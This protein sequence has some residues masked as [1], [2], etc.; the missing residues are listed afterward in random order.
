MIGATLLVIAEPAPTPGYAVN[1]PFSSTPFIT[2]NMQGENAGDGSGGKWQTTVRRYMQQVQIMMLQEVGASPPSTP[3]EDFP[4]PD[5]QVIGGHSVTHTYWAPESST[6]QPNPYHVY[7]VQTDDNG[8]RGTGGRVNT[9]IVT[10]DEPDDVAV[11]VNPRARGR[12]ALGVRFGAHWY[13]S[14][15]GL[16]RCGTDSPHMVR[17]IANQVTAW[18]RAAGVVYNW[19]VAGDFNRTPGNLAHASGDPEVEGYFYHTRRATHQ[20]G[21]ELDY[22][23]SSDEIID[24]R[25]YRLHGAG[26][27]HFPVQIGGLQARGEV[28]QPLLGG[29]IVVDPAGD[30]IAVGEN[31]SHKSGYRLPL[32]NDLTPS[33]LENGELGSINIDG[34]IWK[35]DF[36][37]DQRSGSVADP[38]HDGVSGELID[39]IRNR[40]DCTVPSYR[41]NVVTLHAGTNDM[42]QQ[43]ELATAPDRLGKLIDQI[44]EDA[45]EAVILVATLIPSTKDGMQPRI[46]AY[47]ARVPGVVKDRQD[48]GKHVLLADMSMVTTADVDGSHP[49]DNG[50]RKMADVF[51]NEIWRAATRGWIKEPVP[52]N[53]QE[54][55]VGSKAGPGWRALGTIAPGMESPEGKTDLVELNGDNRADYVRLSDSRETARAALNMPGEPG[56]PN[57]VEVNYAT[58]ADIPPLQ[59]TDRFAD[60]DGDGRDDRVFL[61]DESGELTSGP[62]HHV[63]W[64]RNEGVV[65]GVIRWA[66]QRYYGLDY[67]G[68]PSDSIRFADIDGDGHDDLLRVGESGAIHAYRWSGP[69]GEREEYL[70]WAPGVSGGSRH[71]LRLAD[72]NGDRKADYLMVQSDG[73]VDAYINNWDRNNPAAPGRFTKK[74]NFVNATGYPADKS[75]FRDISGDGKTDYVVIYDGGAIRC[76][77]NLGGNV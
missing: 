72:V 33:A 3:R 59:R 77:L 6:R 18:G 63:R 43:E 66:H 7:F 69:N 50:Y 45:P 65:D 49:N 44:L 75:T 14:F 47:N 57:W 60:V 64:S 53:G 70:N 25:A 68:I 48:Q 55:P 10:H 13:F 73:S 67:G 29:N 40:V 46:D 22:A 32:W 1:L 61:L 19:M 17:E 11:V 31:S 8:G 56:Q 34:K 28:E 38:D 15:H 51:Y 54:C 74:E 20:S 37:G 39:E 30:S 58:A 76:W 27:D 12:T 21:G 23:I 35:R 26:S 41:P 24:H 4:D 9:A 62:V 16:S 52:G 2:W 5:V 36:V 71:Y 42:N